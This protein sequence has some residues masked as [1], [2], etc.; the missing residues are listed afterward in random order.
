MLNEESP[1]NLGRRAPR[2]ARAASLLTLLALLPFA[3]Y[4]QRRVTKEY[5][6]TRSVRLYLKN[7]S[8]TVTVEAWDR[9]KVRIS[10]SM[11]SSS[12]K[13]LPEVSGDGVTVDIERENRGDTGDVN[14]TIQVPADSTVDIQT[15][16]GNIIVRNIRGEVVRARVSTEGDIELTGIRARTVVAENIR[17]N[18]LF[19]ADLLDGGIYELKSVEGNI[20]LRINADS[21]F[22]LTAT[23]PRTRNINL[24]GF[25][26]SGQWEFRGDRRQVFGKVGQGGAALNTTNQNGS[27]V[28]Y[29]RTR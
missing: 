23:A 27:I 26:A 6:A 14:F 28:F 19:D 9:N 11:E 3:A 12:T 18:I 24:G 2:A 8:G 20:Q 5:P 10:A 4:A 25:A 29:P 16:L 15:K 22:R 13:M 21:G 7:R 1:Q 17:G